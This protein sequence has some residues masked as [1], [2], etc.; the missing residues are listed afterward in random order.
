[1]TRA[2]PIA[3]AAGRRRDYSTVLTPEIISTEYGVL[4]ESLSPGPVGGAPRVRAV[5][6][7]SGVRLTVAYR[8]HALTAVR[9]QQGRPLLM[10]Y[11]LAR[12]GTTTSPPSD[13]DLDRAWDPAIA[14]YERFLAGEE[15]FAA[16]PSRAVP[17]DWPGG[18]TVSP[19]PERPGL[20]TGIAAL[21]AAVVVVLVGW[22]LLR[23]GDDPRPC[24]ARTTAT[25][26]ATA[27]TC[28]PTTLD[29]SPPAVR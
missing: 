23:P 26:D 27:P 20:R 9:D 29:P 13:A 28:T 12:T 15:A 7:A 8:T 6:T 19:A 21:T 22:F 14:A 17:T 18:G 1:M 4:A 11:G 24:L 3:V 25:V 5:T 16:L 10:M 2:W